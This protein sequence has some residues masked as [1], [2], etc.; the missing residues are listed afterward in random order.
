MLP[1][2]VD[3]RLIS[4]PLTAAEKIAVCPVADVKVQVRADP[5]YSGEDALI[6]NYIE[7]AYDFL[8]GPD[9]WLGRCCILRE[10]WEFFAPPIAKTYFELPLRPVAPNGIADFEW[11]QGDSTYSAVD[12]TVFQSLTTLTFP[13]LSL[14]SGQVWP[15]SSVF[16]PRAYRLEFTAGFV[17]KTAPLTVPSPIRHAIKILAAYWYCHRESAQTELSHEIMY[18]LKAVAGRYRIGPDHS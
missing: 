3:L 14:V 4:T 10:D 5:N 2:N 8:S 18:G 13:T 1:Q 15:Y 16:N 6:G 9:G 7:A 11:I 17:A 12:A